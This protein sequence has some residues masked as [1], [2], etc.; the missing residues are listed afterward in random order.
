VI[1]AEAPEPAELTLRTRIRQPQ[2]FGPLAVRAR[3]DLSAIFLRRRGHSR[4]IYVIPKWRSRCGV[5]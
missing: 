3:G 4:W 5:S 2:D 1:A